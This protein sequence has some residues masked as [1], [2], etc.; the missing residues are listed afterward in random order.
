[1]YIMELGLMKAFVRMVNVKLSF[2]FPAIVACCVLGVY[3]LNNR[4]F[5]VWVSDYLRLCRLSAESVWASTW[6]RSSKRL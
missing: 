2:L 5:D 4:M 3:T 1:M 6:R